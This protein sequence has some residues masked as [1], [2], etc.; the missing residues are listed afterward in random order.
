MVEQSVIPA[1]LRQKAEEPVWVHIVSAWQKTKRKNYFD[2]GLSSNLLAHYS[3]A[4]S[5][6][7]PC[8]ESSW[9]SEE[10][11]CP[12]NERLLWAAQCLTPSARISKQR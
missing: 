6:A 11:G 9:N 4:C 2:S 10:Q 5:E 3:G 12:G 1:L 7:A 8:S